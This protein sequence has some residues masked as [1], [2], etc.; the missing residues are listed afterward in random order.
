MLAE[1]ALG[2]VASHQRHVLVHIQ[3]R[4]L[5]QVVDLPVQ[6]HAA[7]TAREEDPPIGVD[8]LGQFLQ[9]HGLLLD[10][11]GYG[12]ALQGTFRHDRHLAGVG[13]YDVE[14]PDAHLRPVPED[15]AHVVELPLDDHAADVVTG[16]LRHTEHGRGIGGVHRWVHDML[17]LPGERHHLDALYGDE[18]PRARCLVHPDDRPVLA[19]G[20]AVVLRELVGPLALERA[21]QGSVAQG[22]IDHELAD[23]LAVGGYHGRTSAC[24]GHGCR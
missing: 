19:V 6:L 2:E 3:V 15:E 17:R 12:S 4:D 7:R 24:D 20:D 21:L 5:V 16:P 14:H 8:A 23:D 11:D 22:S 1:D 18:E 9:S 10:D 13:G